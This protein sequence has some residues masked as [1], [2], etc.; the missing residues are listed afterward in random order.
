MKEVMIFLFIA[1]SSNYSVAAKSDYPPQLECKT[2]LCKDEIYRRSIRIYC[3]NEEEKSPSL[4]TQ[5]WGP[6]LLK[7]GGACWCSCAQFR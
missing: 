7:T 3:T 1:L 4:R 5:D 2:G 6:Y